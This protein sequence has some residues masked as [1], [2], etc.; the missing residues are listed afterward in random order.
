MQKVIRRV[1]ITAVCTACALML[2]FTYDYS[3]AAEC[4]DGAKESDTA[5]GK[6]AG[7]NH[8]DAHMDQW[9]RKNPKRAKDWIAEEKGRYAIKPPTDNSGLL[10]GEQGKGHKYG[11]YT[12]RDI[13]M[14]A[15][16][17]EKLVVDG[18]RIFHN[19][20][21]LGSTVAVS[22]DMCHLD[23]SNTHPETYPKFQT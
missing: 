23:A 14:W 15:R 21:A 18:S 19:A 17:T 22:C 20:E 3:I 2:W 1:L 16:E 9:K 11:R 13:L 6:T 12:E 7:K 10:K 8:A 5:A 4:S